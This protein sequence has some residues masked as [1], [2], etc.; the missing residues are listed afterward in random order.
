MDSSREEEGCSAV[1]PTVLAKHL[2]DHGVQRKRE[3]PP[4]MSK[5]RLPAPRQAPAAAPEASDAESD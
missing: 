3:L 2:A 5:S 1:I 4:W